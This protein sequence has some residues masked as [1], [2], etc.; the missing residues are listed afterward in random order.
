[1]LQI[2]MQSLIRKQALMLESKYFIR[3][4]ITP[5]IMLLIAS[6]GD[7]GSVLNKAINGDVKS[8]FALG[9]AYDTGTGEFGQNNSEAVKWYSLAAE[10]NHMEAQFLL[11]KI[12]YQGRGVEQSY[13]EAIKWQKLAAE[14]GHG[15]AQFNIGL[16]YNRG[17][18]VTRDDN[19]AEKWYRQAAEHK[20]SDAYLMLGNLYFSPIQIKDINEAI[21]WYSL[22]SE[23]GNEQANIMLELALK[24][25]ESRELNK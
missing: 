22:G 2:G 15:N 9:W 1:M 24:E 4:F 11:G 5:F 8:Q 19:E 18:G 23:Q 13:S 3:F 17:T 10:Q 25:Y 20:I 16:M 7:D 6:C 21:K 14:Q 12:Y